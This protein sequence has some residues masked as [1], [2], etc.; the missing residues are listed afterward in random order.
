MS[1]RVLLTGKD[2][3]LLPEV[4]DLLEGLSETLEIVKDEEVLKAIRG[5]EEDVKAGR[6]RSYRGF[7][8]EL[9]EAGEL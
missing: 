9:G 8:E 1:G 4:R 6:V 2:R 7:T 5:A 3:A